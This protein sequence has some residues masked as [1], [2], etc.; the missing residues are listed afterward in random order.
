MEKWK[1][2]EQRRQMKG[3]AP[4]SDNL[5]FLSTQLAARFFEEQY[6]KHGNVPLY[7]I[8]SNKSFVITNDFGLVQEAMQM[9][10]VVHK[11]IA[12]SL[13]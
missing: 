3:N 4:M 7:L 5:V 11:P 9:L 1:P 10:D 13:N 12:P 6:E 8:L 2:P